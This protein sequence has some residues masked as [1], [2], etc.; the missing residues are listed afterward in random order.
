MFTVCIWWVRSDLVWPSCPLLYAVTVYDRP[1]VV[2]LTEVINNCRL[3]IL[4]WI[5]SD[6]FQEI[7][8]K[9][10]TRIWLDYE[11]KTSVNKAKENEK[12]K[13]Q[14]TYRIW[15]LEGNVTWKTLDNVKRRGLDYNFH[16]KIFLPERAHGTAHNISNINLIFTSPARV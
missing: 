4:K 3:E 12:A 7:L 13:W 10:L 6:L 5:Y 14:N 9:D 2:S 11:K 1:E 8:I 16:Y 15:R